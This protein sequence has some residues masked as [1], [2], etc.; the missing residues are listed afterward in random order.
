MKTGGEHIVQNRRRLIVVCR[1]GTGYSV[2]VEGSQGTINIVR[3]V[4]MVKNILRGVYFAIGMLFTGFI[5]RSA[6]DA[7]KSLG[8]ILF[9]CLVAFM[10]CIVHT[11]YTMDGLEGGIYCSVAVLMIHLIMWSI[12]F[13][14]TK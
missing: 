9:A 14:R 12:G 13:Y 4:I 7:F 2:W 11:Y 6:I 3:V 10:A 1:V 5:A 8:P